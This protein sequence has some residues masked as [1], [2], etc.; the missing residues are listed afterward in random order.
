MAA[1]GVSQT[2]SMG[3][4]TGKARNASGSIFSIIDRKSKIDPSDESGMTMD[5]L[6]GEIELRHVSFKYPCRPDVQIFRDL[7]LAIRSGKV[8]FCYSF[9]ATSTQRSKKVATCFPFYN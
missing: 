9:P 7:N 8:N 1:M 6:K 4:D 3:P 2:S 5:N